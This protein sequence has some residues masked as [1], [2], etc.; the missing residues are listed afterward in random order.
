MVTAREANKIA[1]A[2]TTTRFIL[3]PP[4]QL[5]QEMTATLWTALRFS[6][7]TF[8]K[9]FT[10]LSLDTNCHAACERRVAFASFRRLGIRVRINWAPWF[11]STRPS[12][13]T[14]LPPRL[15]SHRGLRGRRLLR[16]CKLKPRDPF[17][18]QRAEAV[19]NPFRNEG[20][21][22]LRAS[23]RVLLQFAASFVGQALLTTV[24][25][26]VFALVVGVESADAFT[27]LTTLPAFVVVSGVVSLA[28]TVLTVWLAGRFLDR[29]P[30]FSGFGLRLDRAWW[31]DF[32]FGLVLGAF[33]MTM[34]FLVELSTGW[35]TVT[36]TFEAVS[37]GSFFPAILAPVAFFSCVGFYEELSSRGYQLTNI[38]EGLNFPGVGARGA[39]LLAWVLSSSIFGVLHLLNP[40]ASVASTLNIAFAG[41]MLGTGYVLTGQLAIPVGLHMT[42]NFFQGNVFGFPVSGIDTIGATFVETEQ[43]GPTLFTGGVFGP[44][45]GLLGVGAMV[46]GIGAISLYVRLR[47]G[48]ASIQTSIAEPPVDKAGA[49]YDNESR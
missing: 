37:G 23:W 14:T 4:P 22:R 34:I 32:G 7:D 25:L 47:F 18:R 10:Y 6:C 9:K 31:L 26:V 38:A 42:W 24:A 5:A 46:V 1:A 3:P 45:A 8:I 41:I 28:V 40:N 29:R 21:G 27:R 43:G 44:E 12:A 16:A 30:F 48:E 13:T 35:V 39:V 11:T 49:S 20:E 33:L 36:G 19:T 2:N 15:C 17:P